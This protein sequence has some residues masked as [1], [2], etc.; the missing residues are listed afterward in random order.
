MGK[1]GAF[2]EVGRVAHGMRAPKER[3]GDYEDIVAPLTQK[4][5]QEQASRCMACGVAFCQSGLVFSGA[6]RSTGCPLHNPIPETNDLVYRG[7]LDDA[8]ERQLMMNPFPE[9]TGRVCPAPCEIACNLGLHD[10]AVTIHD[11]ERLIADYAFENGMIAPLPEPAADAK[12]VSVIGSGPAGL[13]AAW[14]LCRR[15][16]RVHV[17]ERD[18]RAGG[19]LMYGIP[20][21]KLPKEIVERRVELMEQ[22]GIEFSLGCDASEKAP[23]ICAESDAVVVAAGARAA[24]RLELPGA[25]LP[26]VVYALD[27][28]TEATKSLLEGR[29]T[30]ISA[31]GRDV[32]VI[33]G[34]D[35]GVDCIATAMRQGAKSVTQVIRASRPADAVDVF[36][37]WPG[38]RAQF[39]TAYG[40]E[41]ADAVF[42]HDPRMWATD[43]LGFEGEKSLEGMRVRGKEQGAEEKVLPAQLALIAKGFTGAESALLK[44]FGLE[45]RQG[46]GVVDDTPVYVC[47]DA[48]TGSS[49][50]ASALRDAL[51]CAEAVDGELRA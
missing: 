47:G 10:D 5:Q 20:N 30:S 50:V 42:G 17:Y 46:R 15:G 12:L 36:S 9:F 43:T 33:G 45:P 34:G 22:S 35:T 14:E 37:V 13:A 7:R 27:Y 31:K 41:E 23:E 6:R 48:K 39:S 3:V 49:I 51:E 29:D 32:I 4:A 24:R 40:Q 11:N 26:G 16:Y 18:D 44:A 25:D 38:P 28:L 8:V 2:L 19:L 21:M 1:P